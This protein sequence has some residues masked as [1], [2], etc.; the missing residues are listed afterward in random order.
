MR[1]L[2]PREVKWSVGGSSVTERGS[3]DWS[4]VCQLLVLLCLHDTNLPRPLT[5]IPSPSKRITRWEKRIPQHVLKKGQQ[6]TMGPLRLGLNP[7]STMW[8]WLAAWLSSLSL[9]DLICKMGVIM[10]PGSFHS[11]EVSTKWCIGGPRYCTYHWRGAQ[12]I[13]ST[14]AASLARALRQLGHPSQRRRKH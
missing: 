1:K 5:F 2:R 4:R 6:S 7:G 12:Y 8:A 9:N 10:A 11:W 3:Q 13:T 14:S